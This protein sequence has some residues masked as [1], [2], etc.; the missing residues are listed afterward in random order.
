VAPIEQI[1]TAQQI[2]ECLVILCPKR[3]YQQPKGDLILGDFRQRL[4]C[5]DDVLGWFLIFNFIHAF[6]PFLYGRN[7]SI[8]LKGADF[9]FTFTA[10]TP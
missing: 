1:E 6:P 2:A 7:P 10:K 8:L 5:L 4:C 3:L 9:R